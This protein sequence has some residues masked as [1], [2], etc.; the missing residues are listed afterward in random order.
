MRKIH[1]AEIQ[2][3]SHPFQAGVQLTVGAQRVQYGLP[4]FL[5]FVWLTG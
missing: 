2:Y 4:L 5:P 1:V 3:S